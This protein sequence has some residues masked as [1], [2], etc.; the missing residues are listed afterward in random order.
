MIEEGWE[1]LAFWA[2]NLLEG[3]P[4]RKGR[5]DDWTDCNF[6]SWNCRVNYLYYF[7]MWPNDSK[8]P[9]LQA[10][11][12]LYIISTP[13]RIEL[14]HYEY[15]KLG[16]TC[17][18][19]LCTDA[20]CNY[21]QDSKHDTRRIS[22]KIFLVRP[23]IELTT[24]PVKLNTLP[25]RPTVLAYKYM[26][27]LLY[28]THIV[29][30]EDLDDHIKCTYFNTPPR[31]GTHGRSLPRLPSGH[32]DLDEGHAW[33]VWSRDQLVVLTSGSRPTRLDCWTQPREWS[34]SV[35]RYAYFEYWWKSFWW[36]Q[37]L[38]GC[39]HEVELVQTCSDQW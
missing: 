30:S 29:N 5:G 35:Y 18:A 37:L 2:H 14:V 33:E 13:R 31:H 24:F 28:W 17:T 7:L 25:I 9:E 10:G 20:S 3:I 36:Q 38:L 11:L 16:C 19:E 6:T 4:G 15:F 39:R 27:N 22:C 8:L 23:K 21:Q 1:R 12:H 32:K 34:G 26:P